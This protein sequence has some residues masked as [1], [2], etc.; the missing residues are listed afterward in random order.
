MYLLQLQTSGLLEFQPTTKK[1][2]TAKEGN[3]FICTWI[4]LKKML[5]SE[6]VEVFTKIGKSTKYKGQLITLT[7]NR[8]NCYT[9]SKRK[10]L[11]LPPLQNLSD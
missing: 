10:K 7:N 4:F 2:L 1:Y 5:Y 9:D 6:K 8:T 11:L 3:R